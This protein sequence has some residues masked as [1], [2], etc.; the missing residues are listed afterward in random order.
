MLY[1]DTDGCVCNII[2]NDDVYKDMFEME[3]FDI[4]CYNESFK[5]Y[6][7]G[8]YEM[9]KLKDECAEN[10]ITEAISLKDKLYAY[11]KETDEVKCKGVK[12]NINFDSLKNAAFNNE[13]ITAK[14]NT[15]KS[16]KDC[17]MYSYTDQTSLMAYT[18]KRFLINQTMSYPY[19]HS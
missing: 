6:R 3:M 9:G 11:K 15:I 7:R 10:V 12:Y 13:I 5:F 14:F 8:Q 16:S 18:D 17:K 2:N 19:G 4:S 1:I